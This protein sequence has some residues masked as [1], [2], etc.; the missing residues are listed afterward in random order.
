MHRYLITIVLAILLACCAGMTPPRPPGFEAYD[1]AVVNVVTAVPKTEAQ[2]RVLQD[3][4]IEDLRKQ[5]VFPSVAAATD[6][7]VAD[8]LKIEVKIT[9]LVKVI[10]PLRI[11]Q[12]AMAGSNEV[13][14]D[15]RLTDGATGQAVSGFHLHGESPDYPPATDWP[16]GSVRIAMERF[17]AQ[18]VKI[19]LDWKKFPGP[20]H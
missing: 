14:A 2:A 12:G 3:M 19:L 5:R 16:R 7:A 6:A 20:A 8:G 4:L 13:S 10:T 9:R 1:S 18:L 15:I 17:N 11:A